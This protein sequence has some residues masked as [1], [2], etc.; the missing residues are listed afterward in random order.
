LH[1]V[2]LLLAAFLLNGSAFSYAATSLVNQR[3]PGFVRVDLRNSPVRLADYRGKVVLLNFWA[4]WCAPCLYEMPRFVQW[5]SKY[6]ARGLQ[7]LGVSMD[8][9]DSPVRA[10]D[11]KLHWN[12]PVMMGDEK[13]GELYGGILGLPVTYLIDPRGMVRARFQG[14]TDLDK[15]ENQLKIL[16][17]AP[18]PAS[19]RK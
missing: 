17:S 1:A 4:T 5:Q 19:S 9:D 6:G 3:A 14:E 10:L 18:H 8:D 11:R 7:V 2:A 13:L 15:I 16:L 12:Y